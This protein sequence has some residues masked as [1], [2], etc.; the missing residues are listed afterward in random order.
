[1]SVSE[2][3]NQIELAKT[4]ME[5]V[6]ASGKPSVKERERLKNVLANH[7][8]EILEA[9]SGNADGAKVEELEAK[10]A[11]LEEENEALGD[12]LAESDAKVKAL[13]QELAAKT[14]KK[15]KAAADKV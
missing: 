10:V 6:V 4:A 5:N 11:G 14:E 13:T 9:L 7:V 8:D 2:V 15:T 1:M 12:A 3:K